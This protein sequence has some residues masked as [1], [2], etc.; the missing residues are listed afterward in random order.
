M[1]WAAH[2]PGPDVFW[3]VKENM[4]F[5]L[6]TPIQLAAPYPTLEEVSKDAPE[7]LDGMENGAKL[8]ILEHVATVERQITTTITPVI[9]IAPP[10]RAYTRRRNVSGN[11]NP[12]PK[13]QPDQSEHPAANTIDSV[14][15]EAHPEGSYSA[16]I[17]WHYGGKQENGAFTGTHSLAATTFQALQNGE[18]FMYLNHPDIV[19]VLEREWTG[20]ALSKLLEILAGKGEAK[21]STEEV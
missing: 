17:L 15:A 10:K 5:Y 7:R 6:V 9:V 12:S 13:T 11:S 19:R 14:A 8:L 16:A 4:P 3:K 2:Q 18:P 21:S 1:A 20:A